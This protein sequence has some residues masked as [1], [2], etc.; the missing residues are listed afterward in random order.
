MTVPLSDPVP[1]QNEQDAVKAGQEAHLFA[2]GAWDPI[3]PRGCVL[4]T[5]TDHRL[6]WH[7]ECMLAVSAT[8]DSLRELGSSLRKY[9]GATCQHHW[10]TDEANPPFQAMRQCLWCNDVI[11]IDPLTASSL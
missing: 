8:N 5:T 1:S 3:C 7:I 10:H 11:L 6:L 2:R 9:L 4:E